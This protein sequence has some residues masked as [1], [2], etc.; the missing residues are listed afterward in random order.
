MIVNEDISKFGLYTG[1]FILLAILVGLYKKHYYLVLLGLI[2]YGTTM[3][4]WSRVNADRFLN[5][6]R[7]AA[8]S[9][10]LFIT[11]Y[12]AVHYFTPRYRNIWFIVGSVAAVIFLINESVYYCFLQHPMITGELL[13]TYQSFSVSIHLL[14]MHVLMTITYMYCS[15]MSL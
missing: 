12:Y 4:H 1:Q 15:L 10:F 3:I 7:L 14:F 5:L 6:D 11:L 9:V 13:K 8:V 2:L